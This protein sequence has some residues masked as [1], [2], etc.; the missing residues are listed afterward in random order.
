MPESVT[1]DADRLVRNIAVDIDDE[2]LDDDVD[3][4]VGLY[5]TTRKG[6]RRR[7]APKGLRENQRAQR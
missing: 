1:L 2:D 5:R 7:R 3:A 6:R 4:L